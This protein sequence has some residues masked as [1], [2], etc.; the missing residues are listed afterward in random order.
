MISIILYGRN[1]S[2][3]YNLHKRAALGINC[4]AEVLTHADDEILFVDYNTPDD[5]PTFPEAI[6]DTLTDAAI[7]R[8]RV[9]RVRPS[10]HERVRHRTHLKA[11]EP[12]ARN[13]ALRRSNPANRWV[14]ST[15]TDMIF[16]PR[17]PAS[18]SDIAGDL[19]DGYYH[20]PR[21]ELPESLW[22]GLDRRNPVDVI[23]KVRRFGRTMYLNEIVYGAECIKYDAPGDFQLMLRRDLFR[24]DGFNEEMLLGWHVDSNIAKRLWLLYAKVGDVVDRLFGYHCDHTRQV[25]P[26]HQ[27][28]AASNDAATFIDNVESASLPQQAD[29]WGFPHDPIEEISLR[30]SA[31]HVYMEG[32]GT[33]IDGEWAQP[34]EAFYTRD[35]YGQTTYE[36]RHVLPFLMDLFA[37]APRHLTVGWVGGRSDSFRLFCQAWRRFGFRGDILIA[38]WSV[39]LLSDAPGVHVVDRAELD[40]RADVVIFD[41][42]EP[43]A[44]PDMEQRLVANAHRVDWA[45]ALLMRESFHGFVTD[46]R[47]RLRE[48]A[49]PRQVVCI[50]AIHNPNQALTA[51][52]ITV[53]STPFASRLR[54]G[55]VI[56]HVSEENQVESILVPLSLLDRVRVGESGRRTRSG[57]RA[58]L[59]R[60]GYLL[61]GPDLRLPAGEYRLDFSFRPRTP[62]T[63]AALLRPIIIEVVAASE[64]LIQREVGS[65]FWSTASLTFKISE[66]CA[67]NNGLTE[68]RIMHG[69]SVDFVLTDITLSQVV[70]LVPTETVDTQRLLTLVNSFDDATAA[71]D[72]TRKR[73][74][75]RAAIATE[76]A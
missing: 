49:T 5:H 26:M 8:L 32:L 38:A 42:G 48:G 67:L 34:V 10:L 25:T 41:F 18:L 3:G 55:Y 39:P 72:A 52:E 51:S 61:T 44:A 35:S 36:A 37:S 31:H 65:L 70:A 21:F 12:I 53:A 75:G 2:Y 23:D 11:I 1:D 66:K 57:I 20:L 14:L 54:H 74:F 30:S 13:V 43:S 9:F 7:A 64:C 19:V 73:N 76:T 22:E 69:R 50:D 27:H 33:V 56:P 24:I 17:G 63:A 46:E 59:G 45:A 6:A 16:V 40:R 4:M 15:N 47:R 29:T 60:R 28:K 68:V 62:F 71:G 58:R